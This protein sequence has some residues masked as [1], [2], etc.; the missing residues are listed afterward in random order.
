MAGVL[1][2]ANIASRPGPSI[3]E[4]LSRETRPVPAA[5]RQEFLMLTDFVVDGETALKTKDFSVTT[6]FVVGQ[7]AY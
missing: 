1:H 6:N 4:L 5:L 2:E 3:Q 7:Y